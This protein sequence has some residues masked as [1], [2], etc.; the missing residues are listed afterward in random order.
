MCVY[1][2]ILYHFS[3]L[4]LVFGVKGK[5]RELKRDVNVKEWSIQTNCLSL[6]FLFTAY[7]TPNKKKEDILKPQVK[8][9]QWFVIDLLICV[10]IKYLPLFSVQY[11]GYSTPIYTLFSLLTHLLQCYHTCS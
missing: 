6:H 10:A 8:I 1:A 3:H 9:C 2:K 4:F 7:K 5:K 11:I